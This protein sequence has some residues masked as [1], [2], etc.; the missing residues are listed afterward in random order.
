M[1]VAVRTVN[2]V[3]T[4]AED[5]V[6]GRV[7][8]GRLVKLAAERH[9]RDLET[10]HERGLW[11]DEDAAESV[12]EF[13][14]QFLRLAEGEHEGQPFILQP[15]QKFVIGSVFGWKMANGYRRFRTLYGEIGKGNGKSPMAAGIGLFGLIGDGEA[16]AEIYSAAV[17]KDQAKISFRDAV[18]MVA[19]SPHLA[20]RIDQLVN[21][22]S[23]G[24]S[25]F[26]PISSERRGLDGKRVH[27]ALI[28][29]IHEH[30][31][32]VVVDKMRAGTKG[33]RQALIIEITNSGYDRASV[34]W[35]HHEYS[36]HI[37]EGT[38]ENDTWFAYVCGLDEGDDW[39]DEAVWPKANPNLGVSIDYR[40]LREQVATALGIPTMFGIV[41]RLNFCIW[42]EQHTPFLSMDRWYD[43][44]P[45]TP[46]D[47][48]IGRTCYAGLD[49]SSTTDIS[50]FVAFFPD[51]EGDGGDV[52]A[53]FWVPEEGILNRS[54]VD[55]VPYDQWARSGFIT[56]TP[57]DVVDYDWII[58]YIQE[59]LSKYDVRE[60]PFDRA[61]ADYIVNALMKDGAPMVGFGQG[62]L[63]MS[64]PTKHLEKL[65]LAKALRHGNNP[66]LSWMA[67]NAVVD[68]DFAEN[69][70]LTKSRSSGRIDGIVALTMALG[71]AVAH[72]Q[73]AS[74][75]S[76]YETRGLRTF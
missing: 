61:R 28:D 53:Q 58:A 63:S 50:A 70:K 25:Y 71:R 66:V 36:R 67:A 2:A 12:F 19:A 47:E 16:A 75:L 13:F 37:L 39:L 20:A 8:T 74:G 18:N 9:L 62:Y 34:C 72:Q 24:T 52:L 21:N 59:F 3:T 64:A 46:D 6:C 54:R 51:D 56:P 42:T 35:E 22:L 5:V 1:T 69:M 15:W 65:V 48:L 49:L 4:Y 14:E 33:R 44:P 45:R 60:I 17:T 57:G 29:E 10:G 32:S 55:H 73:D 30:P 31:T 43:C 11:F 26:R 38:I 68:K 41:Q 7:V 23:I 27:M 76:I 40:Y